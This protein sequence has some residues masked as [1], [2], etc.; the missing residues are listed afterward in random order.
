[1]VFSG[2]TPAAPLWPK[3]RGFPPLKKRLKGLRVEGFKGL[4]LQELG[5]AGEVAIAL[6]RHHDH[7]LQPHAAHPKIVKPWFDRHDMTGPERS[8]AGSNPRRFMDIKT[9][10]MTGAVKETL[11]SAV[12]LAGRKTPLPE[13]GK[14]L[15]VD[16][17]SVGAVPDHAKG[18]L[19]PRL[20]GHIGFLELLRGLAT[21]HVLV[22]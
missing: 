19:L 3:I 18:Y 13:E 1:M 8:R 17:F 14:D 20:Y 12:G 21:E 9:Q 10:A 5:I 7:I 16:F 2:A 4:N 6:G 11:H 15:L 22:R